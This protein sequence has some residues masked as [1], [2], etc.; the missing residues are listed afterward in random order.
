[1]GG[2]KN[3]PSTLKLDD[4]GRLKAE[5]AKAV[6][7]PHRPVVVVIAGAEVGERRRIDGPFV[8]GR[9]PD[10]HLVLS[11]PAVSFHHA[12]IEDRG[13]GWALVDDQSTNGTRVNGKR[14]RE[15]V[16]AANDKI[17]LGDTVLRFEIH[18]AND[19]AY[20]A[21]VQRLL[22][23]DDLSG[24]FQRR[25]F[26]QELAQLLQAAA[27]DRT[28]LGLLVMD[29]DGV[30]AINDAHGHLFG[31]YV[32][33]ESGRVIAHVIAGLGIGARF[34]GD[35]FVVGLP[36]HDAN[37]AAAIAEEIRCA[38]RDHGFEREGVTLHPGIS[39]GVASFPEH[40]TDPATLFTCADKALY[41]AK[42]AG[43][44]RVSF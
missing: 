7:D 20:E 23:I 10:C 39:I 35:E 13:D 5:V 2:R 14:Q 24:L 11:D 3:V 31:A 43:K 22:T 27:T 17:Q 40:A 28:A 44:N 15:C 32:I 41:R 18:D 30:K 4:G 8:V 6:R 37:R 1:M 34:G 29:L 36:K 26:D 16:L 25:H 21:L 38:I 12:R 33:G 19:Q 9:D 42:T